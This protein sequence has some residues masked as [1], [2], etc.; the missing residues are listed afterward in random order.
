MENNLVSLMADL[1]EKQVLDLI[2]EFL[3]QG[4]EPQKILADCRQGMNIIGQRF[5]SGEYYLSDLIFAGDILKR[6]SNLLTSRLQTE[7][8]EVSRG[9]VVVGT[10]KG[11]IHDIGKDLV[12]TM[13]RGANYEVCD[14]GVDVPPDL[15][16]KALRENKAPILGLSGL[17]TIS[18]DAMKETVT[19]LHRAN[20]P[21]R[22]KVM[23]GGGPVTEKVREYVGAD[24]YGSDVQAAVRLCDRW[25][26]EAGK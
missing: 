15:F 1:E 4:V 5:E 25:F 3:E 17:L 12:V 11:D 8:P 23:I 6:A 26:E 22:V 9:R 21:Q 18:F 14:L 10:V 13:L 20:L 19:A 16:I 24:A 7:T 2:R